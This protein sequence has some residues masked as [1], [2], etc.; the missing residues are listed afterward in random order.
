MFKELREFY[1]DEP[2]LF[3][4]LLGFF[5]SLALFL[6]IISN[7][8]V[9]IFFAFVAVIVYGILWLLKTG[10]NETP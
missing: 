10:D 9:I 1:E 4:I 3:I 2:M 7:G 6:V 5:V 8:K